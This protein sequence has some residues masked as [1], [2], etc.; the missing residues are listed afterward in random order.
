MSAVS[1]S[2]VAEL[3]Q[4]QQATDAEIKNLRGEVAKLERALEQLEAERAER[5][6]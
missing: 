2:V 3:R 1:E 5:D 6:C 4:R